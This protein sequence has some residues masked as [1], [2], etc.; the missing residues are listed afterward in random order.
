MDRIRIGPAPDCDL[1]LDLPATAFHSTFQPAALELIREN[2]HYRVVNFDPGLAPTLNRAPLSVNAR[3][4]DGDVIRFEPAPHSLQFFPI[5]PDSALLSRRPRAAQVAPFIEHA[6]LESA[7]TARR[8]D[9]KV[10][11]RE[12]TRELV[13]EINPSTKI[14][15][16]ALTAILVGG[17]LYLGF[18]AFRE[19]RTSRRLIDTQNTKITELTQALS[20]T[21]SEIN[22]LNNLNKDIS[23]SLSLGYSL[24]ESYGNGVC[25]ISGTYIWVDAAGRPLRHA[26]AP[27]VEDGATLE[28]SGEADTMQLSPDGHGAIAE[29][30]VNGTGFHVGGGYI[31]TN[32]HVVQPWIADQRSLALSSSVNAKPRLTKLTAYFP[33]RTQALPLKLRKISLQEEDLAVCT[34]EVSP[35]PADLPALPLDKDSGSVA[36]GKVVVMMGY[37]SGPFRLLATL[38]ENES[39]SVQERYGSS[40]ESLLNYFAQKKLINPLTTQG[41]ITDLYARRIVNDAPTGE[42]GS[43]APVF[44]PSGRVIGVNFA[45]FAESTAS[46][47]AVPIRLAVPL[48]E[49]SGWAFPEPNKVL[50]SPDGVAAEGRANDASSPQ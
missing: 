43:G 27:A 19:L 9:A 1:R 3:I 41:H 47:F 17:L 35:P 34:L 5:T 7:A 23:K 11:L 48:L 18:A 6:A 50:N 31:V 39:R 21:K 30:E 28:G 25:L 40:I 26:G 29:Y 36:V 13:R 4:A 46:N 14:L 42:G 37:T 10:F 49:Q 8:D 33:N 38:P 44:G 22:T 20:G 12:F 15:A 45:I 32:R 16:L 24:R 2:G